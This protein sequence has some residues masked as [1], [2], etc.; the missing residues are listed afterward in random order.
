MHALVME[1]FNCKVP[2]AAGE[3]PPQCG[4]WYR[5]R[6]YNI[7]FFLYEARSESPTLVAEPSIR[8]YPE[9]P[10]LT[11]AYDLNSQSRGL[12]VSKGRGEASE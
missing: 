4:W 8:W 2:Y 9:P 5:S 6:T 1:N 7:L 12:Q 11:S 3:E 10:V